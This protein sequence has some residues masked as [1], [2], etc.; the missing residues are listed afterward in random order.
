MKKQKTNQVNPEI[1]ILAKLEER[2]G[3]E[4]VAGW[5]KQYAPRKLNI[6]EVEGKFAVLRPI[7]AEEVGNYSMMVINPEVG[8]AKAGNYLLNELWIDGDSELLNDEE[9]NISATMQVQSVIDLKKS[10]FCR[11]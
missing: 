8:M 6:V 11:V 1:E 5:Q 10:A 9:Y 2:F 4:K 3:K 7:G